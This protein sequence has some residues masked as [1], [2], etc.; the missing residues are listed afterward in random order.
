MLYWQQ[1]LTNRSLRVTIASCLSLS[2]VSQWV[3]RMEE[4]ERGG[5]SPEAE[6]QGGTGHTHGCQVTS[7]NQLICPTTLTDP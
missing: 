2:L 7:L 4:Q 5:A 1:Q 3:V 6:A